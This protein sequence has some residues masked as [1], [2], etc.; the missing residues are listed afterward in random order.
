M[1]VAAGSGGASRPTN[2]PSC[3]LCP[4]GSVGGAVLMVVPLLVCIA[5]LAGCLSV[6]SLWRRNKRQRHAPQYASTCASGRA[7]PNKRAAPRV[8]PDLRLPHQQQQ[9]QHPQPA[10]RV[11]NITPLLPMPTLTRQSSSSTALLPPSPSVAAAA[12]DTPYTTT[13]TTKTPMTYESTAASSARPWHTQQQQRERQSLTVRTAGVAASSPPPAGISAW[14]Q[15]PA[16][17]ALVLEGR[18]HD[19][20]SHNDIT[21]HESSQT[22]LALDHTTNPSPPSLAAAGPNT[23][24]Y[25]LAIPTSS[26]RQWRQERGV[27][28][29]I[30]EE[31][32]VP[33]HT[34]N[35][36]YEPS[37]ATPGRNHLQQPQLQQWEHR[38]GLHGQR[39]PLP[40]PT[41]A[42]GGEAEYETIP[43]TRAF[44][45]DTSN[46]DSAA[47]A[48]SGTY[49]SVI[50]E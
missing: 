26:H 48:G 16:G 32:D 35:I 21:A 12:E 19:P 5:L 22:R 13:P 23:V 27:S 24:D 1:V 42:D 6:S 8:Q 38:N 28:Q 36:L 17:Y 9:P 2:A 43:R 44:R 25:G 41:A 47:S 31:L 20:S 10:K 46:R 37:T 34:A 15:I 7:K 4:G 49:Y 30:Y 14:G 50:P 29:H 11:N 45:I 18:Q 33:G 3:P 40:Q 39:L